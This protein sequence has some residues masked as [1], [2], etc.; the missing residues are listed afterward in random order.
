MP[1]YPVQMTLV[2]IISNAWGW[3]GLEPEAVVDSNAFGNVI[4]LDVQGRYWRIIP[5][6]WSCEPIASSKDEYVRLRADPSFARDWEMTSLVRLASDMLGPLPQGRCYCLKTP[7]ILG[8]TYIA[9]NIGTITL[10]E[11]LSFAGDGAR[12]I[13]GLP[14]G[15]EVQIK[16]V[17]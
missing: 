12:Q 17:E 1:P 6:H 15:T 11:L 4:V 7:A 16:I 2:G 9:P 5:E 10:E 13:D 8:G 14:E 3:N